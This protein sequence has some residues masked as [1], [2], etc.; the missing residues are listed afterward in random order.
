MYFLI[1]SI[2]L[3]IGFVLRFYYRTIPVV[4]TATK[5]MLIALRSIALCL[6]LLVLFGTILQFNF[7]QKK[8]AS[9]ALLVDD[10]ASLQISDKGTKRSEVLQ[11]ILQSSSLST[12]KQKYTIFPYAFSDKI[13][14]FKNFF[15]D[16]LFFQGRGTDLAQALNS[17]AE[18]KCGNRPAAIILLSDG[19]YTIGDNPVRIASQ[20]NLPVFSIGVGDTAEKSD[21]ILTR[22]LANDITYKNNLTS[23]TATLQGYGFGGKKIALWLKQDGKILNKKMV[24]IP[25]NKMETNVNFEFKLAETGINRL[26]LEAD[27]FENELTEK[28]NI[29]ELYI[30]VLE[31]KIRILLLASSP[32][33]DL[34]F[35]K[36][37]LSTDKDVDLTVRTEKKSGSFYEGNFPDKSAFNK[38]DLLLM[39]DFPSSIT[40]LSI[41]QRVQSAV[42]DKQKPF[43][44][45][46][47]R[48]FDIDKINS[49]Q[50][51]MPCTIEKKIEGTAE[52][53]VINEENRSHPLLIIKDN[54]S[55]S[56]WNALPPLFSACRVSMIKPNDKVLC[57]TGK[58]VYSDKSSVN[59]NLLILVHQAGQDKSIM[60]LGYG[61]YRWDLVMWGIGR[62]NEL[63][64]GFIG[65]TIRWLSVQEE[66]DRVILKTSKFNYRAGEEVF[67]SVQV[68]DQT[69]HPLTGA[70]VQLHITTPHKTEKISLSDMGNGKYFAEKRFFEQGKYIMLA[71]VYR[72]NQM[73][74]RDKENFSVDN[75]N[76]EFVNTR[77]D[78][79]ILKNISSISGGKFFNKNNLDSLNHYIQFEPEQVELSKELELFQSP[80]ILSLIIFILSVDWFLRKRKGML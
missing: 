54:K 10:S 29:R 80:W 57:G 79:D 49:L 46:A 20:L 61:F 17:A 3:V 64:Q 67:F 37:I 32:S 51:F 35:L 74:G 39:L 31:S 15:S 63:L 1:L 6:I 19:R 21:I 53:P 5:V 71:E 60:F 38:Y 16:S 40:P 25:L 34:A 70:K 36:R 18:Q 12:I 77:A 78:F 30:K 41:W 52:S 8:R 68:Y 76:P 33:P 7:P 47:G 59:T 55:I 56:S 58:E 66:N 43:M 11:E 2:I 26:T 48:N 27:H 62:T 13:R 22:V 72:D 75:F 50:K 28:N 44:F 65:N 9:V 69:Y 23:C 45:F 24:T 73:V 14:S 42:K 4:S